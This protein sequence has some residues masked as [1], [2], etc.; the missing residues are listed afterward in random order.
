MLGGPGSGRALLAE[1]LK[2]KMNY[3]HLS[4]GDLLQYELTHG[5]QRGEM[6]KEFMASGDSAPN[7]IV[8]EILKEAMVQNANK[9]EVRKYVFYK[10][11]KYCINSNIIRYQ[12]V[13][14]CYFYRDL[15]L[16]DIQSIRNKRIFFVRRL[17]SQTLS[18]VCKFPMTVHSID[19]PWMTSQKR[20]ERKLI[21]GLKFGIRR[22]S[23]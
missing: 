8:D 6:L 12:L 15:S 3:Y 20:W 23:L 2:S 21:K 19:L 17:L 10:L 5:S 22:P 9:F 11:S 16:M 1:T 4:I 14:I 18:Y 7:H 13:I